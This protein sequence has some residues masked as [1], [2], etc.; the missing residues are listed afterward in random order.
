MV[1]IDPRLH[2]FRKLLDRNKLREA[3][4]LARG[5][6]GQEQER[7]EKDTSNETSTSDS[8]HNSS[9]CC[10]LALSFQDYQIIFQQFH[11]IFSNLSRSSKSRGFNPELIS[12]FQF[13]QESFLQSLL[14][15]GRNLSPSDKD[16]PG[17]LR[18]QSLSL[19]H[20]AK[21]RLLFGQRLSREGSQRQNKGRN[22]RQVAQVLARWL[23]DDLS[24]NVSH[25]FLFLLGERI[26][27]SV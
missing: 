6:H 7:A 12:Q 10:D 27:T 24:S 2:Q 25:H 3:T 8:S 5:F 20:W 14:L 11:S 13:W 22:E 4:D 26:S 18:G 1:G 16:H 23:C 15:D 21:V 9:S 17:T 19:F